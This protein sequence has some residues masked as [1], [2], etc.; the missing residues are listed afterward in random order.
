MAKKPKDSDDTTNP[1]QSTD[2]HDL[3]DPFGDT[4]E[5]DLGEETDF[6]TDLEKV[7]KMCNEEPS[8]KKSADDDEFDESLVD[9]YELDMED[10]DDDPESIKDF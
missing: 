8:G 10:E 5:D 6:M 9:D 4:D 3:P 7:E 1:F 2:A